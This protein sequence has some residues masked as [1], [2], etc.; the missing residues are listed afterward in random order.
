MKKDIP[1]FYLT[2]KD[3]QKIQEGFG[4]PYTDVRGFFIVVA[5]DIAEK[6]DQGGDFWSKVVDNSISDQVL[7]RKLIALHFKRRYN[8]DVCRASYFL[9]AAREAKV[10]PT[11]VKP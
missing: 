9:L 2:D 11:P 3:T 8:P 1:T 4:T 5:P 6:L 10:L 7:E